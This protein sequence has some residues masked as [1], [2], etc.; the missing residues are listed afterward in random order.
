M[1][2]GAQHFKFSKVI[3]S[4]VILV[5]YFDQLWLYKYKQSCHIFCGVPF[6]L[7]SHKYNGV[8]ETE[9]WRFKGTHIFVDQEPPRRL[10]FLHKN[11]QQNGEGGWEPLPFQ[12]TDHR[13]DCW[14]QKVSTNFSSIRIK[15]LRCHH[16][17][18]IPCT[19]QVCTTLKNRHTPSSPRVK[20]ISTSMAIATFTR[21]VN[22][23]AVQFTTQVWWIDI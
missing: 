9:E 11:E 2:D 5:I 17:P 21:L 23:F 12:D 15:E 6:L 14:W 20:D 3:S 1:R 10:P 4:A 7:A 19:T 18:S 8:G 22:T 13:I 16:H